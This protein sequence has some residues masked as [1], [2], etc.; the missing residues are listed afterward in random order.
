VARACGVFEGAH[1]G[2]AHG[3]D[4]AESDFARQILFGYT[5]S[6]FVRFGVN[7]VLFERFGVDGLEGAEADVRALPR[8]V[9]NPFALKFVREF[10]A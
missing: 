5:R 8:R 1:D 4:R 7:F 2:C 9:R 3:E 6:D 10:P